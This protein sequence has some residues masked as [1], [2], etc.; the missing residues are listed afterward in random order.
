MFYPNIPS[1]II[2]AIVQDIDEE[3]KGIISF[4]DLNNY[5]NKTCTKEEN[6]FSESLILKH[7]ASI[8]D[9]QNTSTEKYFKKNLGIKTSVKKKNEEFTVQENNHN[10]YF[11]E[12]LGLSFVDC[13]KLWTFLSVTKNNKNY[14]LTRLTKLV[15]FYR[16]EKY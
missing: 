10:K 8:L 2:K 1:D 4:K 15:N 6:K 7:C 9:S 13:R 12:V 14:D 5:L 11:S 3:S 16:T